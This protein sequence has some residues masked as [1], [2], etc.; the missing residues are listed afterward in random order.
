MITY[1]ETYRK[2][3]LRILKYCTDRSIKDWI[4]IPTRKED[5]KSQTIKIELSEEVNSK[6]TT[7]LKTYVWNSI[8]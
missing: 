2:A 3:M 8:D 5:G 4:L 7:F 6:Y 1:Y